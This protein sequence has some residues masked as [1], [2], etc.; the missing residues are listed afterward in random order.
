[1]TSSPYFYSFIPN[2]KKRFPI[3]PTTQ[4]LS[5]SP[6]FYKFFVFLFRFCPYITVHVSFFMYFLFSCMRE[7]DRISC[8]REIHHQRIISE[9]DFVLHNPPTTSW[10]ILLGLLICFILFISM[11]I[12]FSNPIIVF[13]FNFTQFE[14]WVL[15]SA[16]SLLS[17]CCFDLDSI[18][19]DFILLIFAFSRFLYQV[20]RLFTAI[21]G[22]F[23][24]FRVWVST[25]SYYPPIEVYYP[26]IVYDM[27]IPV[28]LKSVLLPP[29]RG[30]LPPSRLFSGNSRRV[31]ELGP[32]TPR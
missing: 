27:E 20:L 28:C 11:L 26:P 13:W 19:L 16:I 14:V 8:E 32:I 23:F 4:I 25:K 9:L 12:Q 31:Y 17:F 6:I 30:Q 21:S 2:S 22:F 15:L 5:Q 1:M 18:V 29:N 3:F 10:L 24:V 7:W